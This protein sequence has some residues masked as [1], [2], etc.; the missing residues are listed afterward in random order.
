[1][2]KNRI[3]RR[4]A[5]LMTFAMLISVLAVSCDRKKPTLPSDGASDG[6]DTQLATGIESRVDE[7][8]SW[9][10]EE[11]RTEAYGDDTDLTV[12]VYSPPPLHFNSYGE[13]IGLLNTASYYHDRGADLMDYVEEQGYHR[14]SFFHTVEDVRELYDTMTLT[15]LPLIADEDGLEGL[16]VLYHSPN[17]ILEM[18]Y[19]LADGDYSFRYVPPG[20]EKASTYIP[21]TPGQEYAID[22]LSFVL[23]RYESGALIGNTAVKVPERKYR[24]TV[25]FDPKEEGGEPDF[26][27]FRIGNFSDYVTPIPEETTTADPEEE[28]FHQIAFRSYDEIVGLLD[29]M[30]LS[31]LELIEFLAVEHEYY[32][33]GIRTRGDI[34]RIAELIHE[35]PL[36]FVNEGW[37]VDSY[38]LICHDSPYDIEINCTAAG[39]RFRFVYRFVGMGAPAQFGQGELV[40]DVAVDQFDVA[41]YRGEVPQTFCAQWNLFPSRQVYL[42]VYDDAGLGAVDF[43]GFVFHRIPT[44]EWIREWVTMG[45]DEPVVEE[46][47]EWY[48]EICCE[49]E[50]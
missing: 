28:I 16:V 35:L 23:Y 15:P 40:C 8:E 26:S 20:A 24:I 47:A 9:L 17:G 46:P 42:T 21:N 38:S 12:D 32:Y 25:S 41:L 43:S 13:I 48:T 5:V 31:D 18:R 27:P 30:S 2:R 6:M 22:Y 45:Y 7:T 4:Y 10:L 49:T 19:R 1:M 34:A 36:P 37:Q 14:A 50:E 44:P 3:L 33:G 39:Q 29:A 11:T